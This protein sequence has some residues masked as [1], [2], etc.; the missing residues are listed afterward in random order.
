VEN[1]E[2]V[3]QNVVEL[4]MIPGVSIVIC[5]YNGSTRLPETLRHLAVQKIDPGI[6]WEV[7]VID[8][9]SK[10]ESGAIAKKEWEKYGAPTVLIVEYLAKPG[11]N[12]AR[13][14]G[15]SRARYEYVILCDDDNWLNPSY[16]QAAFEI[17]G[18]NEKIGVLG[19]NG[20][21]VFEADPPLWL[22]ESRLFAAGRQASES[23]KVA[24]NRVYG[25]SCVLRKSAY[26]EM[27]QEGFGLTLPD[28]T[29][30]KLLSGG[31]HELCYLVALAGYDIWYDDRLTFDHFIQADR[32]S[33]SYNLRY[34]R[35]SSYC[36]EMLEAYRILLKVG[37]KRRHL[38][39]L[40]FLRSFIYHF[41]GLW[42]A[43]LA[44]ITHSSS[45]EKG[46]VVLQKLLLKKTELYSYRNYMGI[47]KNFQSVVRYK[48]QNGAKE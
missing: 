26:Q 42:P 16:V 20:R 37:I 22:I 17:M 40:E 19:G 4:E 41:L 15:I 29:G 25:A 8:N 5:T 21:L 47:K 28:R 46:K 10:D 35:E 24:S 18:S 12:G 45:T 32:M 23:G 31:D 3:Y 14:L 34:I 36:F 48:M 43:L 11:L 2:I 33:W 1:L 39:N 27:K 13:E 30:T 38:F 6:P 44:R 7:V 9:G